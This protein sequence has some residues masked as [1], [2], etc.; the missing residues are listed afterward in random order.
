MDRNR[1]MMMVAAALMAA[2]ALAFM[3]TGGDVFTR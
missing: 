1:M 3:L 2:L